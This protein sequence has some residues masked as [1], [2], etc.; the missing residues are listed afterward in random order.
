MIGAKSIFR[1]VQAFALALTLTAG[2]TAPAWAF[3]P[4]SLRD[5]LS[6]FRQSTPSSL[7][8]AHYVS[9]QGD[10]F[11]LD[12]SQARPLLKFDDSTEVY[13]LKAQP[14]PRGDVIYM[15]DLGQPVLRATRLGGLTLFTPDAPGGTAAALA[16]GALALRLAPIGP[17]QLFERLAQA[18]ARATHAAR[19]LIPFE[20]EA[21]PVSSALMADAAQVAAEAV[22]R[23][24]HRPEARGPLARLSK[25]RLVE[26][27]KAG[28]SLVSQGVMEITV[29]PADGLA[30]RPSS[31]RIMAAVGL[32]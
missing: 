19:R 20:A 22:V 17:Q 28:A 21:S 32:R 3:G 27:R 26:G 10:A 24:S 30:G 7:P 9:Q 6:G 18:S 25:V 2:A 12:R 23:L 15:N 31:D 29:A 14:A 16:G 4:E 1:G 5:A 11:T 8:V 13:A